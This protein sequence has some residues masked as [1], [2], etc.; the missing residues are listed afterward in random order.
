[1]AIKTRRKARKSLFYKNN[2]NKFKFFVIPIVL[3]LI[4]AFYG[5]YTVISNQQKIAL[6][7]I[8]F[9]KIRTT[10]L[11]GCGETMSKHTQAVSYYN[12]PRSQVWLVS[13]VLGKKLGSGLYQSGVGYGPS[14]IRL[15][16]ECEIEKKCSTM[17]VIDRLPGDIQDWRRREIE[18]RACSKSL[19]GKYAQKNTADMKTITRIS[20]SLIVKGC[21]VSNNPS[22]TVRI[23]LLAKRNSNGTMPTSGGYNALAYLGFDKGILRDYFDEES[24]K[25]SKTRFASVRM[26]V[27]RDNGRVLSGIDGVDDYAMNLTKRPLVKYYNMGIHEIWG[28]HKAVNKGQKNPWVVYG[29]VGNFEGRKEIEKKVRFKTL[30]KCKS[31][32]LFNPPMLN[33]K[34]SDLL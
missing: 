27:S 12:N 13:Q 28:Y 2:Q 17:N 19:R 34:R 14:G 29:F 23:A 6:A 20:P 25:D 18:Y 1:M 33:A 8:K 10:S 11:S 5:I 26:S 9:K 15:N 16:Q 7:D 30:P 24:K 31:A 32:V 22:D 4:L 3:L 21:R